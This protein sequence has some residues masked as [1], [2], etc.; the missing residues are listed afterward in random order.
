M[1]ETI[2]RQIYARMGQLLDYP[3]EQLSVH[4]RE[5]QQLLAGHLPN[6]EAEME[7]F[8]EFVESESLGRMEELY[9]A[10][11]DVTPTCYIFAGYILLGE[12]FKRGE[13][14]VR[15]GEK[16]RQHDFSPGD[17]LADHVAVIF[18]FLAT[19]DES[20]MLRA[21]LIRDCLLP[22]MRKMIAGF[23][24]DAERIN[25]YRYVLQTCIDTLEH[26]MSLDALEPR[27][28]QNMIGEEVA[29]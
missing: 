17:E 1:G 8:L 21:E 9:T 2:H 15:L 13:F 16:Y 19:L 18:R 24:K 23:K 6:A 22:V 12:S 27:G 28:V 3:D 4:A 29:P 25:P 20:E 5:C 14:L 11:F 26:D 10:T 7:T